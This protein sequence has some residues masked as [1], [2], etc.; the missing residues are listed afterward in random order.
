M[1]IDKEKQH[2]GFWFLVC[3]GKTTQTDKS[4]KSEGK[5]D[6]RHRHIVDFQF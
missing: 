1:E 5:R 3:Q 6:S 4:Q 2:K